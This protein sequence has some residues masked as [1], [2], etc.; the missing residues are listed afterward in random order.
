MIPH[1]IFRTLGNSV[2]A[3]T[4]QGSHVAWREGMFGESS[5]MNRL[6][7]DFLEAARKD[8]EEVGTIL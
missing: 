2:L 3:C 1:E 8:A 7:M 5:Y 4:R 6:A